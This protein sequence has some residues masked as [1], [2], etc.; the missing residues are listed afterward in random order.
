MPSFFF[1][2]VPLVAAGSAALLMSGCT[3][4]KSDPVGP[5]VQALAQCL[6]EQK[7]IMFGSATCIHCTNQKRL[8][9][10]SF[11]KITYVE[12]PVEPQR[13][14]QAGVDRYPTWLFPNGRTLVGQQSL[15]VLAQTADCP[16]PVTP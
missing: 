4:T 12:C 2:I 14:A 6:S 16:Y 10:D 3:P 7:V 9:G 8:F 13:C 5:E 1:R 15:S 11:A